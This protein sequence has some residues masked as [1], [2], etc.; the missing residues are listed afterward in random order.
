MPAAAEA[1]A[2][3]TAPAAAARTCAA[4]CAC[5]AAGPCSYCCCCTCK[6]TRRSPAPILQ[7]V[8]LDRCCSSFLSLL[9]VACLPGSACLRLF[10][11]FFWGPVRPSVSPRAPIPFPSPRRD[12]RTLLASVLSCNAM[13]LPAL[14]WT[15]G[16]GRI[17][18]HA[19]PGTAQLIPRLPLRGPCV[20]QRTDQLVVD[21][22]IRPSGRGICSMGAFPIGAVC[23]HDASRERRR[24]N[25][26]ES[27]VS[28]PG[29]QS[30]RLSERECQ[31]DYVVCQLVCSICLCLAWPSLTSPDLTWRE[32]QERL[33]LT[34][35]RT[36]CLTRT[37]FL[38]C[39]CSQVSLLCVQASDSAAGTG[40]SGR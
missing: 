5:C 11:N 2:A 23:T 31:I 38:S 27:R 28:Q 14:H 19:M 30:V 20:A 25:F 39:L 29:S 34:R 12:R 21:P 40:G 17:A 22:R 7:V 33:S 8:Y 37:R 36:S 26:R 24:K 4:G 3:A 16:G 13:H 35:C 6:R 1:A 15:R 32:R 18:L 9:V 10:C